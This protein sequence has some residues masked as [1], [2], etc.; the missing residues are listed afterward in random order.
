MLWV[1][2]FVFF[3]H[4]DVKYQIGEVRKKQAP[5]FQTNKFGYEAQLL[6]T[7]SL[8]HWPSG[9]AYLVQNIGM[10]FI[11]GILN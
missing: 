4:F 11:L 9:P 5:P 1:F 3:L 10:P 2:V 8:D 7:R 6:P